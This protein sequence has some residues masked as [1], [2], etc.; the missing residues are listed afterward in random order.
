MRFFITL[1]GSNGSTGRIQLDRALDGDRDGF[2]EFAIITPDL[3]E[4][5]SARLELLSDR[6]ARAKIEKLTVQN[7]A[8]GEIYELPGTGSGY[9]E[10]GEGSSGSNKVFLQGIVFSVYVSH[11]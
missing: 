3:G 1:E 2:G 8:S 6:P 11:I 9:I 7:I 5:I 4:I 10:D